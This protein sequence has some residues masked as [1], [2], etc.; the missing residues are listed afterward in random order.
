MIVLSPRPRILVIALRRI[1]DVLLTTP[2]IRSL[3][4]AWPDARVE[5]LVFADTVGILKGNPDLD[6]LIALP[7]RPG[8]GQSLK[9]AMQIAKRY[10]LAISTQSGD[11]PTFFAALAGRVS[12]APLGQGG[13][14]GALKRT[15][16]TH[17]VP[18]TSGIHRVEEMLQLADAIGEIGRAHV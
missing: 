17:A 4:R 15:L 11:R 16:I 12:V 10:D 3:R 6:E 7:A 5:V 13:A 14:M 8:A 18:V 1:G 9:L 2:L